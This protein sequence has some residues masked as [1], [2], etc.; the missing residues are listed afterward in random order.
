MEHENIQKLINSYTWEKWL[1]SDWYH[2]FN[3]LYEHRIV[4]FI[5]V[6]HLLNDQWVKNIWRS[7]VNSDWS[8][9]DWWFILWIWSSITY[10]IPNKYLWSVKTIKKLDKWLWDWHNSYDVL[11]R[12]VYFLSTWVLGWKNTKT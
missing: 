7:D 11:D 9:R 12:F 8:T 2:T 1:L 6:C 10:H 5:T 3:E 4:L